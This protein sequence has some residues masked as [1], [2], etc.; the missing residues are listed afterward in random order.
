MSATPTDLTAPATP[1]GFT[2]VRGDGRVD[3]SWTANTEP[4]LAGYRLLPR[5][6]AA[7]HRDGDLLR[8]HRLVTN[9]V[10]YTYRLAA[11]DTHGNASVTT[12]PVTA[13][14]TD[15]D[16]AGHPDRAGRGARRRS[17]D[18]VLDGELRARPGLLPGAARRRRD[19]H[20]HR[21]TAYT[22]AG[23]IND[24]TYAYTAGRGGHPRQPVGAL[25][26]GVGDP[27]RPDRAGRADRA[28]PRCPVTGR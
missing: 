18:A 25:G 10:T 20:G 11:V 1:T 6:A 8:R 4:D 17:G 13:T 26:A 5:R 28:Q 2:A 3:L 22:D 21:G 27:D 16:R 12:A 15:L 7:G 19:R 24:T 14:P 23:L 9:D